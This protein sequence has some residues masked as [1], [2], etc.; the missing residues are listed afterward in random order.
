MPS[1]LAHLA[2]TFNAMLDRLGASFERLQRFSADIAHE[3][4][5]PVNNISGELQVALGKD[6]ESQFYKDTMG[7]CLEECSRISRVMD[8]LLFLAHAEN[9]RMEI[10][11]EAINLKRELQG[12]IDFYEPIA[13]DNGIE[14]LLDVDS[15]LELV[16]ERT[17]FQRAVGNILSNALKKTAGPGFIGVTA[18]QNDGEIEIEIS[19][20]GE[21]IAAEH[22]PHVFDRFYRVDA[23]RSADSGGSGLGLAIVKSIAHIHGGEVRIQSQLGKGTAVFLHFPHF[24]SPPANITIS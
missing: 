6:R 9:P 2:T 4:R 22:L 18:R 11:K 17:L 21:G 19:D 3:L 20:T 16:A 1:E 8:S 5:T 15:S 24:P 14:C 10:T 13:T 12:A 7:S 23:S